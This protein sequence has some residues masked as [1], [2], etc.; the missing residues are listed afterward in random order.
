MA[1]LPTIKGKIQ[2]VE[3]LPFLAC[4]L[5]LT[6]TGIY[7]VSGQAGSLVVKQIATIKKGN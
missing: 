4:M 7:E 3:H 2:G 6:T 1:T 5:V